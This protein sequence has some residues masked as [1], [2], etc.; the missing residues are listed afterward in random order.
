M[1]KK[2]G[3]ESNVGL[4]RKQE[5]GK[6]ATSANIISYTSENLFPELNA[7]SVHLK[8]TITIRIGKLSKRTKEQTILIS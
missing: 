8:G 7:R 1:S 5:K 4:K 3:A 2:Q 6:I